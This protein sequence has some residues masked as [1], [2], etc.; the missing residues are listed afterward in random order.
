MGSCQATPCPSEIMLKCVLGVEAK[1][2]DKIIDTNNDWLKSLRL[3]TFG[4]THEA[5][6][7]FSACW[8]KFYAPNHLDLAGC[9]VRADTSLTQLAVSSS[10]TQVEHIADIRAFQKRYRLKW[11]P[12]RSFVTIKTV[13]EVLAILKKVHDD[14]H[15]SR[16]RMH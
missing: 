9:L 7:G 10:E 4:S 16:M 11:Y 13:N 15:Y 6:I 5:C 14:K 2:F 8:K 1:E 3:L 12:Q